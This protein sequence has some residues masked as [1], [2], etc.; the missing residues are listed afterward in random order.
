M[1]SGQQVGFFFP[2]FFFNSTVQQPVCN[3]TRG[4]KHVKDKAPCMSVKLTLRDSSH[5]Q[6]HSD[7]KVVDGASDPGAS[8]DGIV[9]VADV[10]DP[11]S[12][13]DQRN[14][15]E[16]EQQ[17]LKSILITTCLFLTFPP[18]ECVIFTFILPFF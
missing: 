8:V 7:L 18:S 1:E 4:N 5:C 14:D 10:D 9:E 15:L 6:S 2:Y 16:K 17:Q 11:D 12:D 3:D 13:A